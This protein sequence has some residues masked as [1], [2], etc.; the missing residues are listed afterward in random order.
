MQA[1]YE[2][3]ATEVRYIIKKELEDIGVKPASIISRAKEVDKFEEKID[4]KGYKDPLSQTTDL[5]GVRV[6]CAYESEIAM[7]EN[8]ID[9]EFDVVERVNKKSKLGVDRMGYNGKA[10][11]V[12]LGNDYTRGR[13]KDIVGFVCEIQVRT[14]LQ[15]AWA[16]IDHQLVYK[17]KETIPE[18]L[19]RSLNNLSSMLEV[20]QGVFDSIKIER[21]RYLEYIR[22]TKNRDKRIFLNQ[23]INYDTLIEYS[24]WKYPD[25]NPSDKLTQMI[26]EDIDLEDYHTLQQIDIV[27]ER[28]RDAV[29]AYRDVNPEWFSFSTDYLTKSLGFVDDKFRAKHRFSPRTKKAFYDYQ[30]LLMEY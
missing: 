30:S 11:V 20:A 28:A 21:D 24:R 22:D 3:L 8:I 23:P 18:R 17:Q 12:K 27:V 9:A 7:V 16:I 13:Y 15:D 14:I 2:K 26:L 4:R 19:Q 10:F 29:S 25:L 5:A 6:V 1:T